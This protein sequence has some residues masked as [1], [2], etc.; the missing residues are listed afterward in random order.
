MEDLYQEIKRQIY[1]SNLAYNITL[2]DKSIEIDDIVNQVYIS[3]F[4]K[5]DKKYLNRNIKQSLINMYNFIQRR[6][7]S[8]CDFDDD[9]G[10]TCDSEEIN[11]I[12]L[13]SINELKKHN[14]K[15]YNCMYLRFI[16][17]MTLDEISKKMNLTKEAIRKIIK[18]GLK[19]IQES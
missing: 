4:N 18:K 2:I 1:K 19:I 6:P 7:K 12:I 9:I 13:D 15:I 14:L 8:I 17:K 16:Q 11:I 5:Y 3:I 10:D